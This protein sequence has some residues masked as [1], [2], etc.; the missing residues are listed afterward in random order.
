MDDVRT[1]SH[2]LEVRD[3]EEH[4]HHGAEVA[5]VAQVFDARV[6]RTEHGLQLQARLLDLLPLAPDTRLRVVV[7]VVPV[8]CLM[9]ERERESSVKTS[10][11]RLCFGLF[12]A[13][14]TYSFLHL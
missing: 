1:Y 6:A 8:L 12:H 9:V 3:A 14:T 2:P 13:K 5:A 10:G 11:R 7:C 4:L